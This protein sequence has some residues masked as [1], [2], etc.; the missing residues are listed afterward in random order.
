M[1]HLLER[2]VLA[3][4]KL[5]EVLDAVN[6]AE[7]SEFVD[8]A[9]IA[10]VEPALLVEQLL[11]LG[12]VLVVPGDD[13]RA[14]SADLAPRPRL[15]GREV[16]HLGHVAQLHLDAGDGRADGSLGPLVVRVA[17][18]GAARRLCGAGGN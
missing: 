12:L 10:R 2:D 18:V 11:G 5:D 1:T 14:P 7:A 4:A 8:G 3:L 13:A 17:A 16:A 6:D 15:V 9:D